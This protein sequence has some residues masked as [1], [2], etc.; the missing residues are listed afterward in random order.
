MKNLFLIIII[1]LPI[2][3]VFPKTSQDTIFNSLYGLIEHKNLY[4]TE[5]EERISEIK[6][7]LK[8]PNIT[9]DQRYDINLKLYNE[10]K[11]YLSDSA[12]YYAREN[13]AIAKKLNHNIWINI[14]VPLK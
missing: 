6:K 11:V 8:T 9:D 14:S 10:Y 4:M 12:I 7:L 2:C 5:K 13:T 3:D 1:L